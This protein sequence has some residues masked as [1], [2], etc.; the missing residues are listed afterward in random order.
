VS[1]PAHPAR[2]SISA[3]LITRQ[4]QAHLRECLASVAWCDEIVVVD[5]ASTDATLA[6]CAEAGARVF[7]ET[8][9]RGFGVQ[10]NRALER[11]TCDWAFSI[12]ADEICTPALRGAI[13][14]HLAAPGAAVALDMPRRSSFCG[15]WMRYGGWWPIGSRASSAAAARAFPTTWCTSA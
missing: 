3:V 8:D 9:W 12:D 14:A 4:A 1:G 5:G 11:A 7:T 13:E 6:I 10:K 2:P 15:H